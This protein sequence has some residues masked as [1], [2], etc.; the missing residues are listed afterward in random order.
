[1]KGEDGKETEF[2]VWNASDLKD[3]PIKMETVNEGVPST[4]RYTEVK[5]EKP[6]DALFEPPADFQRYNDV[7]T[8]MREV[9]MKRM[10]PPGGAAPQ[11]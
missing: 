5:L 4:I 1:M 9:M 10:A 2:T 3:F 11:K 7:G 8:M 6:D